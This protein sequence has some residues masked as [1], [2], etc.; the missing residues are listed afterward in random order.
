MLTDTFHRIKHSARG[1]YQH[2]IR[3][4]AHH[5][6][7]KLTA[8]PLGMIQLYAQDPLKGRLLDFRHVGATRVLAKQDQYARRLALPAPQLFR[9]QQHAAQLGVGRRHEIVS[10]VLAID[11]QPH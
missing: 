10:F 11:L 1:V 9:S 8:S 7:D 4:T 5:L 6:E 3:V 2:D